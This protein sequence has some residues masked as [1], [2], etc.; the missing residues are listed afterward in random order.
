MDKLGHSLPRYNEFCMRDLPE[1]TK[2][3]VND[4]TQD[5]S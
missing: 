5:Y 1:L 4:R 3:A 2:S